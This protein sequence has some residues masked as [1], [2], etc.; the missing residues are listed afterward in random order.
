MRV[1]LALL[2]TLSVAH[3]LQ[4]KCYTGGLSFWP[5][6]KSIKANS[7]LMVE[8]NGSS[9]AMI[10]GL[11]TTYEA[12][13][14]LGN[15]RIPLQVKEIL[16]GQYNLSQAVLQP[17]G[18]LK[19]GEQYEL[20][21][22]GKG[23]TTGN[24]IEGAKGFHR[25]KVYY[26]VEAGLDQTAP[27]WISLLQ[28]KGKHY[29]EFGCGP[30]VS[31]EFAGVVYDQSEYLVKAAVQD[32]ATGKATAY[33]LRPNDKSTPHVLDKDETGLISIG[34][35]MC[36]GAFELEKGKRF[37]V[38]FTLVDASGNTTSWAGPPI[39]FTRPEMAG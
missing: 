16:V 12:F 4:A 39:Q 19:V 30:E 29:E 27:V 32:L 26:T 24:A 15:Q 33:Y 3:A 20:L 25:D 21:I 1:I 34:H 22:R 9:Q 14:Q 6:S 35:G 17:S 38:V 28:E 7:I 5:T 37:S 11:G 31:V 8:G 10:Q 13:F 36:V 2:L 18:R 23:A